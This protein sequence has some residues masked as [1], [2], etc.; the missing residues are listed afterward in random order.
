MSLFSRRARGPRRHRDGDP[1]IDAPIVFASPATALRPS[2]LGHAVPLG[3]RLTSLY[4]A[5]AVLDRTATLD[6]GYPVEVLDP[7]PDLE[8]VPASVSADPVKS[9]DTLC[10]ERARVILARARAE[11][12]GVRVLWSGGIDST[13]AAAALLRV[14]DPAVDRLSFLH[15]KKSRQEHPRFLATALADRACTRIRGVGRALGTEDLVVTGEH[16]DQLFGSAKALD[17]SWPRLTSP[18]RDGFERELRDRLASA[19]RVDAVLDWLGPQI[20]RAPVP[21]ETLLDLLW[22]LNFSLK[23]QSVSL[24]VPAQ[25]DHDPERGRTALG[26]LALSEHFF[27]TDG[28][29]RWALEHRSA[30]VRPG[31]WTSY[32]W[33]LKRVIHRFDGDDAYLAAK[34]KRASLG[35]I[36]DRPLRGRCLALTADGRAFRQPV[37]VT[38]ARALP[39][40]ERG[41]RRGARRADGTAGTETAGIEVEFEASRE[42]SLWSDVTGGSGE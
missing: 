17:V 14:A 2:V 8:S 12:R 42:S 5:T 30:C 38:L 31:D 33:P 13:A 23:W 29:Q 32:K 25:L 6:H 16:G 41:L 40:R 3:H 39:G 21:I 19:H 34:T 36:M 28:F 27:R 9:L 15:G 7:L 4:F 18:W 24:R 26:Q 22:W 37:D 35:D 10:L 1:P 11:K 20:E